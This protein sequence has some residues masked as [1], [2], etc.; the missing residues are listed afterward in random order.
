VHADEQ[1]RDQR[2]GEDA[3]DQRNKPASRM[4]GPPRDQVYIIA[5]KLRITGDHVERRRVGDFS[6]ID[7]PIVTAH[8]GLSQGSR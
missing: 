6:A 3:P 8:S 2:Q 5:H 1:E 4:S 7:V